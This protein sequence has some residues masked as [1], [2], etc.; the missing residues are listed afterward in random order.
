MWAQAE[1][2]LVAA[3]DAKNLPYERM[4]GEAVFYGPKIDIKLLDALGRAHQGPTIQFD[5]NEPQRFG[6][7]Y[8]AQDGQPHQVVMVH[9]VVLGSLERFFGGL[10][11]HYAGAFPVWLAPVQAKILPVT[12]DLD[13]YAVKVKKRNNETWHQS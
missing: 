2:S 9:R 5:F 12:N 11:E 13:D 10:I 4:E 6:V 1:S 3:I 8:V 7:E